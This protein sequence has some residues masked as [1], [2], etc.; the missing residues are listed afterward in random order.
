MTQPGC[1]LVGKVLRSYGTKGKVLVGSMTDFPQ[2][3][4]PGSR[5]LAG[6]DESRLSRVEVIES[7]VHKGNYL[8]T[9]AGTI[10]GEDG[11]WKPVD[12]VTLEGQYLFVS[13]DDLV[14]PGDGEYYY[15]ELIGN[16]VVTAGG[17]EIGI[18][19]TIVRAGPQDLLVI[20]GGDRGDVYIPIVSAIV[21]EVDLEGGRVTIDPPDGLLDL[22]VKSC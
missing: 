4:E 8:L 13:E 18:V 3:F 2:R 14:E 6:R 20:D 1:L 10:E 11:E 5:L 17:D 21:K 19:S 16:V 7:T 9:L 12:P 15:H 22:N